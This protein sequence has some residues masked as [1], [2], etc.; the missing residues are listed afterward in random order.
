MKEIQIIG[1]CTD[2][3]I[4]ERMDDILNRMTQEEKIK[5]VNNQQTLGMISNAII[6]EHQQIIKFVA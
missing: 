1:S 5:F 3:L 6:K 4:K 2:I